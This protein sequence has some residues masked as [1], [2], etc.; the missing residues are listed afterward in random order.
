MKLFSPVF[1]KE[2]VQLAT[3]RGTYVVKLVFAIILLLCAS[4][5]LL[6]SSQFNAASEIG[7]GFFFLVVVIQFFGLPIVTPILMSDVVCG[8]RQANTLP[9]LFLTR[10]RPRH[11]VQDKGISRLIT[12]IYVAL[13]SFPFLFSGLLFGGVDRVV[14][15][16]ACGS[17]LALLLICGAC[18]LLASVLCAKVISAIAVSY[19]FEAIA[20]IFVPILIGIATMDDD[21]MPYVSPFW[22]VMESSFSQNEPHAWAVNLGIALVVFIISIGVA[23][24]WLKRAVDE[25]PK[26]RRK[27]SGGTVPAA[28]ER[29]LTGN[30]VAWEAARFTGGRKVLTIV[31]LI[32]ISLI[33]LTIGIIAFSEINRP[34]AE[35]ISAILFLIPGFSYPVLLLLITILATSG[36]VGDR[37]DGTLD[38]LLTTRL[39]GEQILHGYLRALVRYSLWG[40]VPMLS[41]LLA[42]WLLRIALP[43]EVYDMQHSLVLAVPLTMII[44]LAFGIMAGLCWSLRS[45]TLARA[46]IGTAATYAAVIFLPLIV[47]IAFRDIGEAI[48]KLSPAY[49]YVAAFDVDS[50]DVEA[51]AINLFFYAVGTV[52]FY[53]YARGHKLL[54]RK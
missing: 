13:I 6:V 54:H 46:L 18:C 27:T 3:A 24:Q 45:P 41:L 40:L 9:L 30:P 31:G 42:S 10:L 23:A 4:A 50:G 7:E 37:R 12:I 22:A 16:T 20:F 5:L 39:S 17:L 53:L 51:M 36:V 48:I 2:M 21:L 44:Y 49:G 11:I 52:L 38:L 47:A 34:D 19:L 26:R 15:L 1:T 25:R 29:H 14:L 43:G 35:D 33:I 8:E 28:K 32:A